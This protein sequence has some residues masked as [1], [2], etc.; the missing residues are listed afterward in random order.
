MF[1][2]AQLAA[3]TD[4]ELAQLS[5]EVGNEVDL[6][7]K[8][9]YEAQER[10]RPFIDCI[11]IVNDELIKRR[12]QQHGNTF[13]FSRES[14]LKLARYPDLWTKTGTL[15]GRLT[16]DAECAGTCAMR[17]SRRCAGEAQ[18]TSHERDVEVLHF[19]DATHELCVSL[20]RCCRLSHYEEVM[21]ASPYFQARNGSDSTSEEPFARI[22]RA[23]VS[24]DMLSTVLEHAHL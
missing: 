9:I 24:S 11:V 13:K 14:F 18:L 7:E 6:I 20:C 12:A 17:V 5:T 19:C 16:P 22:A 21:R 8:E 10:L 15:R 3:L 4:K 23:R 2:S 1:T